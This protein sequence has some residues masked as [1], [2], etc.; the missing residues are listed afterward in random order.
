MQGLQVCP[1]R[2]SSGANLVGD[3]SIRALK[4]QGRTRKLFTGLA[5]AV[6][7]CLGPQPLSTGVL[8]FSL[9]SHKGRIG[10]R[11]KE[12]GVSRSILEGFSLWL[13]C[14]LGKSLKTNPN[15]KKGHKSIP[16]W[17]S[18]LGKQGRMKA[19]RMKA[20]SSL[21]IFLSELVSY[22]QFCIIDFCERIVF[23]L[24]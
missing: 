23:V 20:E 7:S 12:A 24:R 17:R 22:F 19:A 5:A 11:E 6:G 15:S 16:S 13:V 8:P 14:P 9:D 3:V 21:I 4:G 2:P 10:T 18:G 1:T